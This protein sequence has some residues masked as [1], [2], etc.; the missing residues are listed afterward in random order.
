MSETVAHKY[1]A[2]CQRRFAFYSELEPSQ[3]GECELK[4]RAY[5][6]GWDACTKAMGDAIPRAVLVS[7]LRERA[8][9]WETQSREALASRRG[10]AEDK[11]WA[12]TRCVSKK[13]EC[14]ALADE[15]ERGEWPKGEG[16]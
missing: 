2:G 13:E 6:A 4:R 15:I 7:A 12:H 16:K 9:L 10:S 14:L 3:C 5:K 8:A 1:C 11:R